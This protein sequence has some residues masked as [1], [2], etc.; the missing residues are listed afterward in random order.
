MKVQAEFD[1]YA[2]PVSQTIISLHHLLIDFSRIIAP[3]GTT[4]E[5]NQTNHTCRIRRKNTW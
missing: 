3:S 4:S 2:R 1:P 5:I